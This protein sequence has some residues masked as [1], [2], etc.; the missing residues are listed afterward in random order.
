M[1]H[2]KK[3]LSAAF[4]LL[5]SA[6]LLMSCVT[7]PDRNRGS[8]SDGMDKARDDNGA[9]RSV[10]D[11]PRDPFPGSYPDPHE[12]LPERPIRPSE[13]IRDERETENVAIPMTGRLW[14]GARGG[15]AAE[16]D[17]GI[18]TLGDYDIFALTELSPTFAL[19][20]YAGIKGANPVT[21]SELDESV[22]EGIL[23]FKAGVEGRYMPFPDWK[24]F[25]P[26]VFAGAGGYTMFWSFQNSLSAG[27][28]IIT[29][30]GLGGM[31]L[32]AGAGV[33]PVNLDRFRIGINIIP[34][35]Y[36]F[37]SMTLE[38]F[39]NDYFTIFNTVKMSV[40]MS[41]RL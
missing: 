38:G 14:I 8:L 33:Y 25:S 4:V 31:L 29:G 11:Y 34:E 16:S 32:T 39:E 10:P 18:E 17:H 1:Y 9:D 3:A 37:G 28:D 23:F 40:E 26:Y 19:N 2:T 6:V 30:D 27:G 5:F 15:S 35:T 7:S 13:D 36:L 41:I 22:K 21:D 24:V 20:F 12:R